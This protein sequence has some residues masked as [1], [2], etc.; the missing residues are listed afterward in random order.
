MSQRA[1]CA[2]RTQPMLR[3]GVSKPLVAAAWEVPTARMS[4]VAA[5][6]RRDLRIMVPAPSIGGGPGS[7]SAGRKDGL[8]VVA[9]DP[10]VGLEVDQRAVG[11][12]VGDQLT[13]G[14]LA[15]LGLGRAP[16]Q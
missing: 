11:E 12:G 4:A 10:L 7:S 6:A 16:P 13:Q 5:S 14:R 8:D 15:E 3:L 9:V 2:K 1:P